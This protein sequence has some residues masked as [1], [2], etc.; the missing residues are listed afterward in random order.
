MSTRLKEDWPY[1]AL[2]S[3][4]ANATA[5]WAED[6]EPSSGDVDWIRWGVIGLLV[7]AAAIT[8]LSS[9]AATAFAA[10]DTQ[11]SGRSAPA[12]TPPECADIDP[13]LQELLRE[14]RKAVFGS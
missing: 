13:H 11:A 10:N 1:V 3:P 12:P 9:I 5:S 2:K 7:G 6:A 8:A 4:R 14:H